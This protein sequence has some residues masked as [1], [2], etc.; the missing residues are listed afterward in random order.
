MLGKISRVSDIRELQ[1]GKLKGTLVDFNALEHLLDD[2]AGLG[3]WQIELRKRDD[4]PLEMDQVFVHAVPLNGD[5]EAL[6]ENIRHRFGE[7]VEFKPND[8]LF[9]TWDD[10][11]RMQGVGKELKEQKVV[12]HRPNPEA[13]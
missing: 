12:D 13:P 4:D 7:A 3:A 9:H 11:R 1:V 2:T 8:I 6:R 5:R 10:M